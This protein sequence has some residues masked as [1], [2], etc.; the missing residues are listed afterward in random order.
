MKILKGKKEL[1]EDFTDEDLTAIIK[2]G[3]GKS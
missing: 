2:A 1:D 3:V